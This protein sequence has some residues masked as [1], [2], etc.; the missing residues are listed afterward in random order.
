MFDD[1]EFNRRFNQTRRLAIGGMIV[2]AAV[3]LG[4][5]GFA[6]WVIVKLLAHFGV[7]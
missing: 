7:I 2:S 4:V 6:G 5:L 1:K 3:S